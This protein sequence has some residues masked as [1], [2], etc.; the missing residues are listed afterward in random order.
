MDLESD[1]RTCPDGHPILV[2]GAPFLRC[3]VLARRAHNLPGLDLQILLRFWV[4]HIL[5]MM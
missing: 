3:A 4:T 2:M 5:Y 1:G